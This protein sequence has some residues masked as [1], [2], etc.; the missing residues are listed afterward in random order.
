MTKRWQIRDDDFGLA[1]YEADTG[2]AALAAFLANKARGSK[3][4]DFKIAQYGDGTASVLWRG[5]EYRTYRAHP[6]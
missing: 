5:I 3:A 6:A 1:V 4:G 2:T